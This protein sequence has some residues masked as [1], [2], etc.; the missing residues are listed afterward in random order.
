MND[1][2]FTVL[3]SGAK[4]AVSNTGVITVMSTLDHETLPTE[5]FTVQMCEAINSA[6]CDTTSVSVTV[7]DENDNS[8]VFTPAV[9]TASI[10][11]EMNNANILTITA[12]DAD[13]GEF[14]V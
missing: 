14:I 13:D 8:P 1:Y 7:T 10:T 3:T 2:V 11:E 12:T 6:L 9:F 4:F 5:V